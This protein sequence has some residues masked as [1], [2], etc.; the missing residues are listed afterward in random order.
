MTSLPFLW[1]FRIGTMNQV[2]FK[3]ELVKLVSGNKFKLLRLTKWNA[4]LI[5]LRDYAEL[6]DLKSVV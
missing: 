4:S 1:Q 6:V 3:R 5:L 2:V